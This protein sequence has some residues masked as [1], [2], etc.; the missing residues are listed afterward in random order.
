MSDTSYHDDYIFCPKCK[1]TLGINTDKMEWKHVG[2]H[3]VDCPIRAEE[4][5][6]H[7]D[8]I[9]NHMTHPD[10][11]EEDESPISQEQFGQ[12]IN[13]DFKNKKRLD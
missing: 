11:E 8:L 13:V 6:E 4:P 3:S 5:I 12:V 7:I 10:I 9:R 1:G 2:P